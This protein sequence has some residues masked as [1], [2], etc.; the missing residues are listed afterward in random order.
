M[1]LAATIPLPLLRTLLPKNTLLLPKRMLII[2]AYFEP[3]LRRPRMATSSRPVKNLQG[4]LLLRKSL[5]TIPSLLLRK[6]PSHHRA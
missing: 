1:L 2:P 5:P 6:I 3:S 4:S